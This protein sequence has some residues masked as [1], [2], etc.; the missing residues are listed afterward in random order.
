[1]NSLGQDFAKMYGRELDRLANEIAAY[2]TDAELWS[3]VGGQKN[4]PGALALHTVGSLMSI[5]GSGLGG[6]QYVR[7]RDRE[8]SGRNVPRDE[9]VRVIRECRGTVV[10]V[11][12]GLSDAAMGAAYSGKT[13]PSFTGTTTQGY[14]MHLLWHIGWH[15]G[16]IYYHR[17]GILESV[18]K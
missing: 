3:T 10:S 11:L 9:V 6:V 12:E 8:F 1:M 15:S 17:L 14:L 18:T 13:S 16:H 4:P 7:D 5:I 2:R